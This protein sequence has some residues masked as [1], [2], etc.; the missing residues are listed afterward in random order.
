MTGAL[1]LTT[2]FVLPPGKRDVVDKLR[3]D[4][5]FAIGRA[6][7]TEINIQQKINELSQRSRGQSQNTE[8]ESV[9]SHFLGRFTLGNGRLALRTLTFDTPGTSVHLIGAYDL[10]S[11]ALAFKG[12]ILM[13]AKVS[14]TQAG[15]KRLL[16]KIVDPLFNK[17]GGGSAIPIKIEGPLSNPSFGLDRRRL[18]RRG[19]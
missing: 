14:E 18:F 5:Q 4:G 10:R 3:L 2:K 19:Q 8:P 17:K 15:V 6:R 11:E 7:F 12:T 1:T 16:L 9:V 13:D